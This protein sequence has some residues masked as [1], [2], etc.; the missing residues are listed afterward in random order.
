[1]LMITG[2]PIDGEPVT[3]PE[4]I[5]REECYELI[6]ITPDSGN[7]V[8]NGD[9]VDKIQKIKDTSTDRKVKQACL[10]TDLLSISCTIMQGIWKSKIHIRYLFNRPNKNLFWPR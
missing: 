4:H 5:T 8:Y 7:L 1:M 9:L 10:A 2:L 3:E 6:G